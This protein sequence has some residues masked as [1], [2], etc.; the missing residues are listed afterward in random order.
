[1]RRQPNNRAFLDLLLNLVLLF[2]MLFAVAFLLIRP[3]TETAKSVEMKAELVIEMEWPGGSLDDIDLWV[4]LP[5][6]RRVGFPNKDTGIAT[7]DR[8]DRGAWGDVVTHDDGRREL[9][10]INHEV[11]AIRGILPGRYVVNAHYF[12]NYSPEALGFEE[13]HDGPVPAK[14]KLTALNPRVREL[15]ENTVVLEHVGAQATALAFWV[16]QTGEV[17]R[18]DTAFDLPFVGV[19]QEGSTP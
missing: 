13:T 7:L 17:E 14:I 5:D 18:V 16:G 15:A 11:V 6:G 19:F 4:L 1:M 2:V 9:I 3:P 10:R 8:D 12:S